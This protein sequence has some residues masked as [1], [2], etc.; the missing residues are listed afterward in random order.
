[1][2][3]QFRD[4]D[5]KFTPAQQEQYDLLLYARREQVKS[6]YAEGRV[7]KGRKSDDT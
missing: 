2:Q 1:M 6:F 5:F 4:Q 3:T 7:S